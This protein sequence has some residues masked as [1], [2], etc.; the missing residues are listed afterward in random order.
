MTAHPDSGTLP[1]LHAPATGTRRPAPFRDHVALSPLVP[2]VGARPEG[3]LARI[4]SRHT[5]PSE[6]LATLRW[7]LRALG[8][9]DPQ[10]FLA[11][12]VSAEAMAHADLHRVVDGES[13]RRLLAVVESARVGRRRHELEV[14]LRRM[15][16][17]GI[18]AAVT[19]QRVGATDGFHAVVATPGTAAAD[20]GEPEG[21]L[22]AAEISCEEDLHWARRIGADL[23]EG[24]AV[25][26][27]VRV[28]PVDLSRL[29]R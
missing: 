27:P 24:A 22:I 2:D 5:D 10:A 23:L 26:E 12:C 4:S 3:Y 25:A 19:G 1:R 14:A 16:L 13:R 11:A 28:A 17:L 15:H 9:L 29:R 18:K 6:E 7:T 8:V 21:L 20:L